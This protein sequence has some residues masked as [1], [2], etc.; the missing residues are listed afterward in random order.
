MISGRL[1]TSLFSFTLGLLLAALSPAYADEANTLDALKAAGFK[2]QVIAGKAVSFGWGNPKWTPELWQRLPELTDLTSLIAEGKCMDDAG[3]DVLTKLPKLEK[4]FI[5]ASTFGDL[6]FATLAKIRSLKSMGF[7]HNQVFTGS[8]IALL[9][10][11]P[12]L[13]TLGLGGCMKFT[14]KGAY[15]FAGW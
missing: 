3:L 4:L 5:N 2:P 1:L 14:T 13:R 12:N 8:G 10:D 7:D 11:S 9:K 15:A 6:G